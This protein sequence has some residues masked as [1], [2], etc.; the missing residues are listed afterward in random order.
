MT[1]RRT[2]IK[3]Y[4]VSAKVHDTPSKFGMGGSKGGRIS[5]LT[6]RTPGG[7]IVANYD[8]GWDVKPSKGVHREVLG[9]F[10]TNLRKEE[11]DKAKKK[12]K[13]KKK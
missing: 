10:V 6:I 4:N 11:R 7:K 3:G 8:R 13:R 9:T 5:K 1:D 12:K 2:K